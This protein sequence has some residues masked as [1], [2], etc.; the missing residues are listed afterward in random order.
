MFTVQRPRE[1]VADAEALLDIANS[2]V[3]SV[4]SHGNEGVTPSDF[5]TSLLGNYGQQYGA[6]GE[7]SNNLISWTDVGFAV[8]R[9]F[10]KASGCCTMYDHIH[11][12]I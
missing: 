2:L 1:Q 10:R 4:K 5:I 12:L 3:V 9:M 11:N 7:S 8:S 6:G